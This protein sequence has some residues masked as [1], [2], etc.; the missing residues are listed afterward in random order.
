MKKPAVVAKWIKRRTMFR[1]S[2]IIAKVPGSNP[3]WGIFTDEFIWTN[4][5][6]IDHS[7]PSKNSSPAVYAFGT[8]IFTYAKKWVLNAIHKLKVILK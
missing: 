4:L 8:V 7:C 1:H 6:I 2:L 3:A 5:S